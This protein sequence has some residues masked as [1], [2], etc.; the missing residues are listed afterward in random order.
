[1]VGRQQGEQRG[2]RAE[3]RREGTLP[4]DVSSYNSTKAEV[5][6]TKPF[7]M[8][9]FL[10]KTAATECCFWDNLGRNMQYIQRPS[11]TSEYK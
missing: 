9:R 4:C 7:D 1:M 5:S 3:E 11:Q 10:G 8:N 6:S 2:G